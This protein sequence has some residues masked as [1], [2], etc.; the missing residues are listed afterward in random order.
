MI[1]VVTLCLLCQWI[2]VHTIG[3]WGPAQG[4]SWYNIGGYAMSS[5]SM[6]YCSHYLV[7]GD[8]PKVAAGMILVVTLYLLCQWITVHTIGL[9]GPA[10]GGSWYNIGCYAIYSLSM[11]CCSHYWVDGDQPKV[12]AGIILVVT[13]YLLCQWITV[14]TIGL[15]GPA[16]GGSWYDI[17][18][19]AMSSLSLDY[20]SHYW[21]VGTSPRWQLV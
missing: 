12:A 9:W 18:G 20:C 19:Y 16:Q 1:L 14:H 8:Q 21:V 13:L 2:T 4:G 3:L 7:D 17:G 11:D 5:L 10:Q 6:D 15:W